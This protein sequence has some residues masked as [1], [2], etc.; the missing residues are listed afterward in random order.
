MSD[1]HET[2][3]RLARETPLDI[4]A[5]T[6]VINLLVSAGIDPD[7]VTRLTS[8]QI[9]DAWALV[10]VA[11]AWPSSRARSWPKEPDL[12]SDQGLIK[13]ESQHS[14]RSPD[15]SW[16]PDGDPAKETTSE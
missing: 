4:T 14:T 1:L 7:A 9:L 5:A 12:V 3:A 11:A 13:V 2:V 10:S 16:T 6:K 15:T 8:T